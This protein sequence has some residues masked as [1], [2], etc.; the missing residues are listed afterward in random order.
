[1]SLFDNHDPESEDYD[2]HTSRYNDDGRRITSHDHVRSINETS[3]SLRATQMKAVNNC[4]FIPFVRHLLKL[5]L[6][7][8]QQASCRYRTHRHWMSDNSDKVN[9]FPKFSCRIA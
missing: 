2:A 3:M 7:K 4:L 9:S 6:A 8:I 1:M 5:P